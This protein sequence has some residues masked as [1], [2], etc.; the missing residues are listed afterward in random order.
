MINLVIVSFP[1]IITK[2]VVSILPEK[3]KIASKKIITA[4]MLQC[5]HFDLTRKMSEKCPIVTLKMVIFTL[6]YQTVKQRGH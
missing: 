2:K 4:G 3:N 5:L 1:V 6:Y